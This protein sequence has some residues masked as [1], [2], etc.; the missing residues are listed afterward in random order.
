MDELVIG[1]AT[2]VVKHFVTSEEENLTKKSHHKEFTKRKR[3]GKARGK[4]GVER[5]RERKARD[6]SCSG[7]D[8]EDGWLAESIGRIK[9]RDR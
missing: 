1:E 6:R 5:E 9:E 8:G 7:C 2:F 3:E 4:R